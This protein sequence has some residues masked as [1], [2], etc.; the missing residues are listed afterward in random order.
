MTR[1]SSRRWCWQGSGGRKPVYHPEGKTPYPYWNILYRPAG[2]INASANE[3]GGFTSGSI[4]IA[5][6]FW[7]FHRRREFGTGVT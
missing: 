3:H 2:A 6:L 4:S 7:R 5:A 1:P